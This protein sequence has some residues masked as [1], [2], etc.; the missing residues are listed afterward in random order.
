MPD[1]LSLRTRLDAAI[2]ASLLAMAALNVLVL[3]QQVQAPAG[4]V[5]ASL[6]VLA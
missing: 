5:A 3:A 6:P 1:F 4:L 2:L